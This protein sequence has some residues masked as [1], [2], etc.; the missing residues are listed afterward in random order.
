MRSLSVLFL[1]GIY[2]N[3]NRNLEV[4]MSLPNENRINLGVSHILAREFFVLKEVCGDTE[5]AKT[6]YFNRIAFNNEVLLAG[7]GTIKKRNKISLAPEF[8]EARFKKIQRA[9]IKRN[10]E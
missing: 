4:F 7:M 3:Y 6:G 1:T 5:R 8:I 10:I 9:R 2:L